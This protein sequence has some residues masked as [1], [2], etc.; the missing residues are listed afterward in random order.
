MPLNDD[1]GQHKICTNKD[2]SKNDFNTLKENFQVTVADN[3][4]TIRDGNGKIFLKCSNANISKSYLT[5]MSVSS[6]R[7]QSSGYL[8]VEKIKGLFKI[9]NSR[10][11]IN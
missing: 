4:I 6:G 10:I 3:S 9:E 11:T 5:R 8:H 7:W 2:H 1:H